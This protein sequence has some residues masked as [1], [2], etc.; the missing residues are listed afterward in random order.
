MRQVDMNQ[1]AIAQLIET[2]LASIVDKWC[3]SVRHDS[4]IESD[5]NL[6]T[7]EL[8]DHVP[9]VIQEICDLI[10]KSEL[11]DVRNSMEARTNA[12]VRFQQ[13]YKGRDLIRELSILRITLFDF[14]M[15]R[16]SSEGLDVKQY[17]LAGTIINLYIDEEMRYVVSIY[18]K[19][20]DNRLP[21]ET[22][23]SERRW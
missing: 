14:L 6:T 3:Q 16:A 11:P 8:V 5:A 18:S 4:R 10:R 9:A 17:H 20:P 23:S 2:D 1:P 21:G 12:Y 13:G 7:P 19:P 22:A 15:E